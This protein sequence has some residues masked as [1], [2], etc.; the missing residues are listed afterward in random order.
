MCKTMYLINKVFSINDRSF[1]MLFVFLANNI[2]NI[3]R[4]KDAN[5][6]LNIR[7]SG[8]KSK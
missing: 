3:P 5:M 7:I 8:Q 1:K 4:Q 6:D 2:R